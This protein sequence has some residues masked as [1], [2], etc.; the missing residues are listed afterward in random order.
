V[1]QQWRLH[2]LGRVAGWR[3]DAEWVAPMAAVL[4]MS[5]GSMVISGDNFRNICDKHWKTILNPIKRLS[6]TRKYVLNRGTLL[7]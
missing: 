6:W 7:R 4:Q 2:A 3:V 5:A 1:R